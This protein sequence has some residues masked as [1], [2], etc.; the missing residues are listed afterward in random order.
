MFA[1]ARHQERQHDFPEESLARQTEYV[2]LLRET[3]SILKDIAKEFVNFNNMYAVV[4]NIHFISETGPF[5]S[6]SPFMEFLS[7]MRDH[8]L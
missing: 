7:Q 1:G 5:N 2:S 8:I 4:H 6:S 3:N